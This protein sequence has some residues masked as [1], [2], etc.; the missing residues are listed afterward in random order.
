MDLHIAIPDFFCHFN[1]IK[2]SFRFHSNKRW[3][4]NV[5]DIGCIHS[6]SMMKIQTDKKQPLLN[7]HQYPLNA[8]AT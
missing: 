1:G 7:I 2:S 6:A 3:S 5:T 8:E 4:K